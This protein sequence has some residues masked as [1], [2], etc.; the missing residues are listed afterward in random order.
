[1][2]FIDLKFYSESL[3][4]QSEVYVVIPQRSSNGEIGFEGKKS[5]D[6]YK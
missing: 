4:M 1:M 3:G 5:D 2:A 6:K